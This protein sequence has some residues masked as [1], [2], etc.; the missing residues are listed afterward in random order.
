MAKQ[1]EVLLDLLNSRLY[2]AEKFAKDYNKDVK[3]WLRDYNIES[4]SEFDHKD[5]GNKIQIPYIFSTIESGLPTMFERVPNIMMKQRG[6]LDKDFTEF[7]GRIWDYIVDKARIEEKTEH[8]G[9]Y[10]LLTGMGGVKFGWVVETETI[11]ETETVPIT[12]EDGSPVAEQEVIKQVEVP[13]KDEPFVEVMDYNKIF[14]APESRFVQDDEDN[15]IPNIICKYTKT[16]DEVEFEY[17]VKVDETSYLNL[18]D[19]DDGLDKDDKQLLKTDLE[20]VDVFEYYGTLPKKHISDK[21]WKPN[22]V[23]YTVFTKNKVLKKPEEFRKKPF[24][25]VDNYGDPLT[26]HKFG[27]PKIMREL[28]QDISL[29]RSRIMDYRDKYGTKIWLPKGVEVD[30]NALKNPADFVIM[31]GI[32]KETPMYITPPPFPETIIQAAEMS[33]A[34]IQ[35]VSA[36]LDLARGSTQSVV[37]TATGQQIFQQATEKRID[38]KRRKIAKFLK[39]L[40]K[41]LLILCGENW[42]E[43]KLHAITDIPLEEIQEKQYL[44]KLKEI[45]SLYDVEIDIESVTN[46]KETM[47]AQSIALYREVKDDSLVNR[48]EVLKQALKLGFGITDFDR[49]LSGTPDPDMIMNTLGYLVDNQMIDPQQAQQIALSLREVLSPEGKEM[50]RPQTADPTDVQKGR[51]PAADNTQLTSQTT[52]AGKQVGIPKGLQNING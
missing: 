14:F 42:D 13:I 50:G 4:I 25:F 8:V 10:M 32:S 16:P 27:E 22:K 18:K 39:Y 9:Q 17:G 3:K 34:D 38:R 24:V 5:I 31:R 11:D 46:N 36:Q 6:N 41:N 44:A 1:K 15:L 40:A 28:E 33:R 19:I 52:A 7:A 12:N 23:Y 51:Q 30:E 49:F 21:N 35:M 29:G 20:R 47:A 2:L 45:G 37:K 43:E 26:F 48:A